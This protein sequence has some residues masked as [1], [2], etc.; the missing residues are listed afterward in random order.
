M[1]LF[2][3]VPLAVR[4]EKPLQGVDRLVHACMGLVTELGEVTTEIKRMHIYGKPFDAERKANILEE[5]G[6]V[7]W[8]IAILLNEIVP[9][10]QLKDSPPFPDKLP[11]ELSNW[12]ALVLAL[13]ADCGQICICTDVLGG[14]GEVEP[15][16]VVAMMKSIAH[17]IGRLSFIALKC[18]STIEQALAANIAKLQVRYPDKY[19]NELAEGRADKAGADARV[20]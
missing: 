12:P 8:Y 19:S 11:E 9:V 4:T 1:K 17:I 15:E 20:S 3:Y 5:I 10:A 16:V 6:D 7:M 2:E 14:D 18:D 13:G